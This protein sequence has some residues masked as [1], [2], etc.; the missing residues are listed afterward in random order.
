MV[1]YKHSINILEI[2]LP[3][4]SSLFKEGIVYGFSKLGFSKALIFW[5]QLG[6]YSVS[7]KNV[8]IFMIDIS[9]PFRFDNS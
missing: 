2:V 5:F 3:I 9:R 6:D 4:V 7:L 1:I 8:F